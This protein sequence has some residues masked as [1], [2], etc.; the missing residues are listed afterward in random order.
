MNLTWID[1]LAQKMIDTGLSTRSSIEGCSNND[2]DDI[3]AKFKIELPRIY[4]EY[5]GKMG[6][7]SG[8]FLGECTTTYPALVQY[9]RPKAEALLRARA[10]Y[11]LPETAFVFVERYG[12]QFFFFDT[13][14]GNDNP[15]VYRYYEGDA[16]PVK[17]A[18]TLTEA[19]EMALEDALSDLDPASDRPHQFAI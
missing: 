19:L 10:A 2:I 1:M 12:C 16:D 7:K 15:P 4:K 14:N 8:D 9:V 13:A 17:I 6:R 18:D 5:L 3:E 11:R